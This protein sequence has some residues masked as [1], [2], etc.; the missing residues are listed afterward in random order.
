VDKV[1]R[2]LRVEDWLSNGTLVKRP[3]STS[4]WKVGSFSSR[5]PLLVTVTVFV[6]VA[7][8]RATFDTTGTVERTSTSSVKDAKPLPLTIK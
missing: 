1:T 2:E 6:S 4:V 8:L 7:T 3:R 5:S